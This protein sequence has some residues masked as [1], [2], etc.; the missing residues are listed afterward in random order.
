MP[1]DLAARDRALLFGDP[2]PAPGDAVVHFEHGL[3]RFGG[4]EAVTLGDAEQVLATFVYRH[5]GKLMLPAVLGTDYWPYGAPADGLTLDRLKTSDW[6]RARDSMIDELREAARALV[7]RHRERRSAKAVPCAPDTAGMKAVAEG[8]PHA[9]TEDQARAIEAVLADMAKGVPMER[10]LIGDVG[11]GKTEVAI[12][13]LAAA[14][15]SGQ[16]AILAAPTTVLVRQHAR[17]LR[18]RLEPAGIGVAEL[19]RLVSGDAREEALARI[20]SGEAQVIVGTAALLSGD[21]PLPRPALVVIDEEQR[22]GLEQKDALR[23]LAPGA[24]VLAMS[25]TPI[26]RSLAAAEIGILDIGLVAMPPEGRQPVETTLVAHDEDAILEAIETE[27]ARGGQC[28]VVVPRIEA[29]EALDAALSARADGWTHVL[30]HGQLGD[31]D[32]EDAMIRFAAGEAEVLLSTTIVESGLD[33]GRANTMV[34]VDADLLGL[35]QLH[36][37][38][39]RVGRAGGA[40][41]MV[42]TTRLDLMAEAVAEVAG[43]AGAEEAPGQAALARLRAFAGMDEVGAGFR[44]ARIDRDMRGFG[45]IAGTEQSGHVSRLGLGLYAHVLRGVAGEAA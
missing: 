9:P 18:E 29:A 21:A 37:L 32:L 40:A 10:L 35:A 43:D 30:A 3:A 1:V 31:E 14:A 28:F 17:T 33:V 22:F 13:A 36:Q 11:F 19:S 34:V 38:R 12:R 42:M 24:H 20:A 4:E 5:G 16:A 41:R 15:L 23:D 6:A 2:V 7:A 44:I 27:V 39:G 8:F 45:D 25:A 26:P